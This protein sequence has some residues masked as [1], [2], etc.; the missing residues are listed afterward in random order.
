[1]ASIYQLT[2][3]VLFIKELLEENGEVDP[4]ALKGALEVSM[5]DLVIKLE[6]YCKVIKNLE[7][8]IEGLKTEEARLKARRTTLENTVDRMKE[9]MKVAVLATGETKLKCG[10]FTT[11]VQNN[12]PSVVLDEQY[13]ENYP[14]R[15]LIP[16][17]PKIDKKAIKAAI[18]SGEDLSGLAHIECDKSLRIR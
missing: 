17:D 13:V 9:A 4:E 16:Q 1:M 15:F 10:T 18:E 14:D 12:P 3:D 2:D 5:E 11:A 7:S 8:D 6:S